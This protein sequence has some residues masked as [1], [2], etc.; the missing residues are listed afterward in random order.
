MALKAALITHAKTLS[1]HHGVDG[2]RV[3]SVS[4]GP[5][6]VDGGAWEM[7]RDNMP[8]LY[9]QT[10]ASIPLGRMADADEI[11]RYISFVASPAASYITGAN[12]VIDG[13]MTK[14]VG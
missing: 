3:N 12:C 10:L 1:H 7:V 2:I 6:F 9:E 11:G 4:P 13:G 5:V 14:T 8:E